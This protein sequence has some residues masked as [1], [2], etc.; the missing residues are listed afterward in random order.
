FGVTRWLLRSLF[1]LNDPRLEVEAFGLR[2]KNPVGLAAGY[3]KNGVAVS[4]LSALGFG[5]LEIG[6]VTRLPQVGNPRP[7]IHRFPAA[8]ALVNSMGFPNAGIE[9]L[10]ARLREAPAL[11]ARGRPPTRVGVNLGKGRDTPS[12]MA[13]D[14]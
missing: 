13:V 12:E 1:E 8:G 6:T 3:D 5:H 9:A 7:R 10:P 4:G 14:D 2:F 11:S